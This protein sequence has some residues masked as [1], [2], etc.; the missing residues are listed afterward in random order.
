MR[1]LVGLVSAFGICLFGP[2]MS[3]TSDAALDGAEGMATADFGPVPVT[4][5]EQIKQWALSALKDP[6]SARF[7]RF[8]KP[9][10]EWMVASQKAVFGYSVC[11]DINAKNSY[12]GYTG[13]QRYWF[14]FRD[15]KLLRSQNTSAGGMFA[16]KIT[17]KHEVNCEDGP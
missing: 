17:Y 11:A 1:K 10:K 8:S 12:G 4:H 7:G 5:E 9:R 2:A 16:K 14:F 6:E 13:N 15:D 3:Q